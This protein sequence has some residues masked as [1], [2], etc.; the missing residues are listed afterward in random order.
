MLVNDKHFVTLPM[1]NQLQ[2]YTLFMNNTY[3]ELN[4]FA[5]ND[6]IKR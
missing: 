5:K 2:K 6:K 3:S 4:K 1:Q